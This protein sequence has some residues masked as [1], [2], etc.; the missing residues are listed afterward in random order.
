MSVGRGPWLLV[1]LWAGSFALYL[2]GNGGV[3]LWDRD[4]PR[5]A[6]AT[7]Q[8]L[9]RGDW[10][11]PYYLTYD[12]SGDPARPDPRFHKPPI[13][14]WTQALACMALGVADRPTE[15]AVRFPSALFGASAVVV[16]ALLGGVLLGPRAGFW[17]A[18]VLAGAPLMQ[19]M[20]K[21]CLCDAPLIFFTCLA[22]YLLAAQLRDGATRGR[23]AAMWLTL[24]FGLLAKGPVTLLFFLS[25]AAFIALWGGPETRRRLGEALTPL[26][27]ASSPWPV[28]AVVHAAA[29]PLIMLAVAATWVVP[30][31]F[32][33]WDFVVPDPSS[34]TGELRNGSFLSVA[35]GTHVINRALSPM[36][37]HKGWPGY[38]V[39]LVLGTFFPW[40]MFL[41]P[42]MWWA[43]RGAK[44]EV[45]S[46]KSEAA[47]PAAAPAAAPDA[48]TP[49]PFARL[50][51]LGWAVIPWVV[52]EIHATKLPHYFLPTLPALAM[53]VTWW[54]LSDSAGESPGFFSRGWPR[55]AA[56]TAT[57]GIIGASVGGMLAAA[58]MSGAWDVPGMLGRFLDDKS[59]SRVADAWPMLTAVPASMAWWAAAT[60]VPCCWLVFSGERALRAGR[61]GEGLGRLA[62]MPVVGA[63]F[64]SLAVLPSLTPL[65]VSRR[66]ADWIWANAPGEGRVVL[67][68]FRREDLRPRNYDEDS[69]VFYLNG[70]AR[71][72]ASPEQAVGWLMRP[73]R[74]L[75]ETE[76]LAADVTVWAALQ[77]EL[78]ALGKRLPEPE[79]VVEGFNYVKGRP[80]RLGL[81]RLR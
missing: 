7:V 72:A 77:R 79:T 41:P 65:Q 10:L 68:G 2:V 25:P 18:V 5:Y 17:S 70:R 61:V 75:D 31:Q 30:I 40:S 38:F 8:M 71:R 74:G 4:E 64:L 66:A 60:V 45:R 58:A 46:P 12:I 15:F 52:L 53:L 24:G 39:V 34:P 27:L 6:Q 80:V 59:A 62:A 21:I 23:S 56:G 63:A 76:V 35:M 43:M 19:I 9:R 47:E 37:S 16:V 81:A 49:A 11:V 54:M 13:V 20:C 32:A 73:G 44:S 33:T 50:F 29:G 14:Y 67:L 78:L 1:A 26:R 28:R 3:P 55:L 51:L 48:V 69:L 22:L 36:E 57:V 42:A